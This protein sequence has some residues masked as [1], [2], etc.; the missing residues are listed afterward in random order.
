MIDVFVL[1]LCHNL[2]R[3]YVMIDVFECY[4]MVGV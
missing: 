1:W 4:F 2:C 3:C